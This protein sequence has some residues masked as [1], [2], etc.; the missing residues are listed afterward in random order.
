MGAS[1]EQ[2]KA[3]VQK[4]KDAYQKAGGKKSQDE[5]TIIQKMEQRQVTNEQEAAQAA[6]Q[7]AQAEAK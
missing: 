4:Y 5:Q 3:F 6:E 1:K 7:A 2:L